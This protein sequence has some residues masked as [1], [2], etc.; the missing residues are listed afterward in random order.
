MNEYDAPIFPISPPE[1]EGIEP[2]ELYQ[3]LQSLPPTPKGKGHIGPVKSGKFIH[4]R[5]SLPSEKSLKY[6]INLNNIGAYTG[7]GYFYQLE[8]RKD[9]PNGNIIFK[10]EPFS[11]SS[12]PYSFNGADF[13]K[14]EVPL[15]SINEWGQGFIDIFVTVYTKGDTWTIYKDGEQRKIV[16]YALIE[17]PPV[18]QR[19]NLIHKM[20]KRE[21]LIIPQPR[22]LNVKDIDFKILSTTKIL[23]DKGATEED[24]FSAQLL[25]DEIDRL[26]CN[27]LQIK[28]GV[29][30][31]QGNIVLGILNRDPDF[32]NL[33]K[34][35]KMKVNEEL[36]DQ[37]YSIEVFDNLV[38]GAARHSTGLFYA[39][40]TLIQLLSGQK[41]SIK[42]VSIRDWPALKYRMVQYDLARGQRVNLNYLKRIIRE[43]SKAKINMLMIYMEDDFHYSKYPFLG[44][45]GTFT[46]E[47]AKEL[48]EY[49][50]KY[51]IQLV[52]QQQSFGHMTNM[53]KHRELSDLR[54]AGNSY[55]I[56]PLNPR[57]H[58][59]LTDLFTELSQA[60][61]NSKFIH[62]GGDEFIWLY[63]KCPLCK[64]KS[65]EI[66]VDGLYSLH[67]QNIY[68]IIKS[69]GKDMMIWTHMPPAEDELTLNSKRK[70]LIPDDIIPFLWFYGVGDFI[71]K[72][73]LY[74]KAGF[75]K[76]FVSPS[77]ILSANLYPPYRKVFINVRNYIKAAYIENCTGE[78]TC[79]WGLRHGALFE[80]CWYGLI[81]SGECAWSPEWTEKRFYDRKFTKF[82][83]G[84]NDPNISRLLFNPWEEFEDGLWQSSIAVKNAFYMPIQ[85]FMKFYTKYRGS[86]IKMALEMFKKT[87]ALFEHINEL[88]G[89]V[90][91]KWFN[92]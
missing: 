33:V 19:K 27:K 32:D 41:R 67:L 55:A 38:F 86:E 5:F 21:I 28:R 84:L 61:K 64:S 40:Q 18:K 11:R 92:P 71:K 58:P 25:A 70:G 66:G 13:S 6:F 45:E 1:F 9:S 30:C 34:N 68:E 85:K 63:G 39:V 91:K 77:V 53:L 83:F 80:T 54:E 78:C 2:E 17:S 3:I 43:L 29:Q 8:V 48:S 69:L 49:A 88:K 89:K 47:L 73:R 59:F 87:D 31:P 15:E 50:N 74:K 22:E 65:Q 56:C 90:T 82:W 79:T 23:L 16:A 35:T 57:T 36:G 76:I 75:K 14:I 72:I 7:K 81:Y 52:P 20:I 62:V 26:T 42:G 46:P 60:F 44:R 37:G 12:G 10:S 51:N 24:I 4:L